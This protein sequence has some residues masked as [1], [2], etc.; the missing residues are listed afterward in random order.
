MKE[1][2]QIGLIS[3]PKLLLDTYKSKALHMKTVTVLNRHGVY[4]N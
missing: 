2:N 1:I 3:K 4:L